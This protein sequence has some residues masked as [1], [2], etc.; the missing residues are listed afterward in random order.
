MSVNDIVKSK[1]YL[2]W[3]VKDQGALSEESV[4]EH[5]LNYGD[6]NDVQL[7]IKIKGVNKTAELFN[8]SLKNKRTNYQPAIQ[9][10][11]SRYFSHL[12]WINKSLST[13]SASYFLLF[14]HFHQILAFEEEEHGPA[15]TKLEELGGQAAND[16]QDSAQDQQKVA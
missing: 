15:R 11:F 1:P 3:Y 7:F 10:Y 12:A 9:S 16:D 6:W 13:I 5:V 2:A 8:K 14:K 4:L